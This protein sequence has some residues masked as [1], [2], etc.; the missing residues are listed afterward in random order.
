MSK[1]ERQP[2]TVVRIGIASK[3]ANTPIVDGSR[4]L[5]RRA[6]YSVVRGV[7]PERDSSSPAFRIS[8]DEF[9]LP[10]KPRVATA[11]VEVYVQTEAT[12]LE[13]LTRN[14]LTAAIIGP[15]S[16]VGTGL[17]Q[18]ELQLPTPGES[19]IRA[20]IVAGQGVDS[21]GLYA[22]TFT[23]LETTPDKF[24]ARVAMTS[25][26]FKADLVALEAGKGF[27]SNGGEVIPGWKYA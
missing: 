15:E 4:M 17:R 22:E 9:A 3:R 26:R 24:L 8:M 1:Q 2:L 20:I 12:I 11:E 27:E 10:Q 14:E 13:R 7:L 16:S 19:A 23:G 25:R 6:G 18:A 5:L 21:R